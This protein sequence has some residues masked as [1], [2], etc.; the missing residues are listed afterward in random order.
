M[1]PPL[2]TVRASAL[3]R[4]L[5]NGPARTGRAVGKDK[6]RLLALN[7]AALLGVGVLEELGVLL[8]LG[9]ATARLAPV[10]AQRAAA[11]LKGGQHA[12]A[13]LRRLLRQGLLRGREERRK[14]GL[15]LGL[16]V[17]EFA[18]DALAPQY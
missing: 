18:L 1:R 9:A 15:A 6:R 12:L 14:L 3:Q 8:L 11:S 7:L 10:R 4:L 17:L 2:T 13:T 16:E 5:R